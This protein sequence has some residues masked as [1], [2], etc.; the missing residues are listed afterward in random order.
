[1]LLKYKIRKLLQPNNQMLALHILRIV[2]V[3]VI[4]ITLLSLSFELITNFSENK[5]KVKEDIITSLM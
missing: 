5:D 2:L 3:V 1:M 4:I